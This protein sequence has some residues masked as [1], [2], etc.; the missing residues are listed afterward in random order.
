MI[1]FII[2]FEWVINYKSLHFTSIWEKIYI[3]LVFVQMNKI[4]LR[5]TKV[6]KLMN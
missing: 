1:E 3:Y 4:N 6:K 5:P 2:A